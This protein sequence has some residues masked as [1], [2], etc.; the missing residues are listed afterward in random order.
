VRIAYVC[1]DPGVSVFGTKGSSIHV[2]EVL[3]G[4]LQRGAEVELFATRLDGVPPDDL[5]PVGLHWL[6]ALPKGD[7]AAREQASIGANA[8]LDAALRGAGD[9]DLVYERYSLWSYSAMEYARQRGVAG[10]LEV[11]AP[12]IEE[13]QRH[14]VLIDKTG[15]REV[16]ARVFLA[17]SAIAVVSSE[18]G[19]YLHQFRE[20]EGRVH[21]IPNGVNTDR[22][23]PGVPP[24]FERPAGTFTVGFVGTLKPWHGLPMLAQGFCELRRRDSGA[25]LLIGGDGPERESFETELRDGGALDATTF[26]GPVSASRIPNLLA[27]MDVG[28]APYQANENFY[29][30]PLKVFEYMAAG[31]PI[32]ASAVGQIAEVIEDG[33]TGVLCPPGDGVALA[34]AL[35]ELCASPSRREKLG[36][37]ARELAVSSHTW[38]HVVDQIMSLVPQPATRPERLEHAAAGAA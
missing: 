15:A 1:A 33:V 24:L 29:F 9:F 36:R 38:L 10:V 28:V 3:R 7:I 25:R 13:Q 20:T 21:L 4:F 30:S 2:Q 37:S 31:L 19:E 22:I 23:K 5:L 26:A 17:A 11:N 6:P 34:T 32:V 18:V 35:Q 14:R 27:S 12:L 8:G 16:A